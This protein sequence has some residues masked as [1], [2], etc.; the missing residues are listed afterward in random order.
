MPSKSLMRGFIGLWAVAGVVLFALSA[1]TV[2]QALHVAPHVDVHAA[3]LGSAEAVGAIQFL[4]PRLMRTGSAL[5]LATMAVAFLLHAA[6]GQVRGD[7]LVYASVVLFVR[8]HGPLTARQWRAA[9][10]RTA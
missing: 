7:L 4:V 6:M 3:L 8:I 9:L 1:Q 2:Y 5:L 10:E